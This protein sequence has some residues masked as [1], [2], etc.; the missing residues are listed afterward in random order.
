M[1]LHG[2]IR[3]NLAAAIN[4]ARRLRGHPVHAD[5]LNHWTAV[6]GEARR[7]LA[8]DG[9]DTSL[10]DLVLELEHELADQTVT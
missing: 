3:A 1:E 10:R 2:S 7:E 9:A 5:T 8:T 4:S 6:L